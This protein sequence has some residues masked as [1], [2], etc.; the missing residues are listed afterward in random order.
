MTLGSGNSTAG[1]VSE[2]SF[3][4]Q[5]LGSA[6]RVE[7]CVEAL[8]SCFDH[9]Q[10]ADY[11]LLP[12][13]PQLLPMVTSKNSVAMATGRRLEA[14][15]QSGEALFSLRNVPQFPFKVSDLAE[16][17]AL[18]SGLGVIIESN[19]V[20]TQGSRTVNI[21]FD[22]PP[23]TYVII[24]QNQYGITELPIFLGAQDE[25]QPDSDLPCAA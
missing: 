1:S 8:Q 19:I 18:T 11:I 14:Q 21:D 13:R 9:F 10:L 6:K 16:F 15:Q 23:G 12:S 2:L 5:Q 20:A 3:I 4:I 24:F 22:L 7:G 17:D 25:C